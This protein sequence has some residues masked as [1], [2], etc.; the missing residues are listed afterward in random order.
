MAN[1][2]IKLY[3]NGTPIVYIILFFSSCSLSKPNV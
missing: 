3:I 2:Q 1:I